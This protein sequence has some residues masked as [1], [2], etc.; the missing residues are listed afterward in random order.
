MTSRQRALFP[1]HSPSVEERVPVEPLPVMLGP[2]RPPAQLQGYCPRCH[3]R[4]GYPCA[5]PDGS[6][7][8]PHAIRWISALVPTDPLPLSSLSAL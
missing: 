3:Q 2:R 7:T 5:K 8:E 4:R 6:P 1:A